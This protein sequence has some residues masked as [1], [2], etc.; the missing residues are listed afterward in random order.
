MRHDQMISA[1][2][3]AGVGN[4]GERSSMARPQAA[5]YDERKQEIVDN[6]ARLFA[7]KSFLGTSIN[8]I[9]KSCGFSKSLLYH[10]FGSK[11]E[12]LA[13]VMSSHIDRLQQIVAEALAL[14]G[15]SDGKLH[16]LLRM[17]MAE[18]AIASDK[19]KVLVNELSNLPASDRAT[20]ITKQRE[21][22]ENFQSLLVDLDQSLSGSDPRARVKTMLLF[23]MINWTGNWYDPDGPVKPGEVADMATDLMLGRR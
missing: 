15:S 16:T 7:Q 19:Q 5:D 6:A 22:V 10:Y 23:G 14:R 18:Y 2:V 17:F 9:A 20:I 13:A 8:D 4:S 1:S 11:E 21:I 12:L 3:S